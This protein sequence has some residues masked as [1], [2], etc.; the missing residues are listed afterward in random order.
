MFGAM[1]CFIDYKELIALRE[2][3]R[4]VT[5][6]NFDG[7]HLG[8]KAVLAQA[9]NEA[10]QLDLEVAVLTFEPHPVEL[11]KPESPRQ[12]LVD[13]E[14]KTALLAECGSDVVLAQRFDDSFADLTAERFAGDVLVRALGAKMVIVGE[15]FRFGRGREGGL[16]KLCK[17]GDELGFSVRS[18]QLVRSGDEE[19]SSTRIRKLI[20]EGDVVTANQLLGRCHALPGKV[21][22]GK[23][24]GKEFGYPTIN[25]GDVS[26]LVPGPGIYAAY[27]TIDDREHQAAVYIGDRPTLGYGYT[28]EAFLIDY[29]G[30]LYGHRATLRFVE[31]LRGDEKFDSPSSLIEQITKDVER[32]R[33]ILG[34]N[35]D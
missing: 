31:R 33:T 21:I 2:K 7:V 25:L 30:D 34:S 22:H 20:M 6:G 3:S 18:K 4:V 10:D 32:S 29:S 9:R 27:C 19:I 17:L 13:P 1:R 14:R 12:R 8:H 28:I 24:K 15:N 5:I 11:L 26:V 16:A 35:R 23:G